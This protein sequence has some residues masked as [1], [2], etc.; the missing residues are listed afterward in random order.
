MKIYLAG[1]MRHHADMNRPAFREAAEKLRDAGHFVFN[2]ADHEAGNLR[3]NLATDTSWICLVAEA[4]V[5]LPGWR[6]SAGA[7]AEEALASA[8]GLLRFE[9]DVFLS[10]AVSGVAATETSTNGGTE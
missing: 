2:P 7:T 8:L 4:V 1:P 5:L 10:P 6:Q 3:A 9:L